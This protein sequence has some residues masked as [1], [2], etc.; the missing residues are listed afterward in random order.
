MAGYG[1]VGKRLSFCPEAPSPE[2]PESPELSQ[3]RR[4]SDNAECRYRTMDINQEDGQNLSKSAKCHLW[5]IQNIPKPCQCQNTKGSAS[6]RLAWNLKWKARGL[7]GSAWVLVVLHEPNQ[8][9]QRSAG[10]VFTLATGSNRRAGCLKPMFH[11]ARIGADLENRVVLRP[12]TDV[13]RL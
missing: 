9:L 4:W 10:L 8:L 13:C 3:P 6:L 1:W 7:S 11:L 12:Q 5:V 2:S